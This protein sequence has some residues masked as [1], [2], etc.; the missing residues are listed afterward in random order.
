MSI[1]ARIVLL[2]T[3]LMAVVL[4]SVSLGVYQMLT[5]S[6]ESDIDRRLLDVAERYRQESR[7]VPAVG[8]PIL[9]AP[10]DLDSFTYPG[11]NLQIANP[12][13][14]SQGQSSPYQLSLDI[15]DSVV[16][17]NESG[18]AVYF[19]GENDV[20]VISAPLKSQDGTI[21]GTV[22]AFESLRPMDQALEQLQLFLF[23][24]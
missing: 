8:G 22:Q 9:Q 12:S 17:A 21:F 14:E 4:V 19:T 1:R 7:I 10:E 16:E 5:R 13:G 23:S 20:R 2:S 6:M 15:P 3:L 11:L 24:G 18:D